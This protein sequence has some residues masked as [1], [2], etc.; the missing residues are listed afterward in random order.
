MQYLYYFANTSLVLRVLTYLSQQSAMR[1]Q[2]VTVIY[3]IDR[4][5]IRICPRTTLALNQ[6][7][8]FV[9]FLKE[10]GS[11]YTLTPRIEKALCRLDQGM[12]ITD[13]M[14]QYHVVIVSHGA[15]NPEDIEEF[16]STFV[17]GLGYC[18]PSLV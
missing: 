8:N 3:L 4:W 12:P 9:S 6:D 7:L 2:S 17:Q 18:P 11:S 13:V 5:I 10:N 15:L 1:L 16:R 14:N